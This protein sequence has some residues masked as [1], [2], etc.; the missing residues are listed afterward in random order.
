M[1]N[2]AKVIKR[3]FQNYYANQQ[4]N[5]PITEE[6]VE[7][8]I[9]KLK[10]G[11]SLDPDG[12]TAGFYKLNKEQIIGTLTLVMNQVMERQNLPDTWREANITLILKEAT[13]T[14]DP[15]NFR[16]I[17]L[18]NTDY[19]LFASILAERMKKFYKFI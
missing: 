13:D 6:E 8:A 3:I 19:K 16:P 2:D 1:V 9:K 4:M 15:K 14:K 7:M 5:Q 18:L 11:K 10:N 17:S 12:Y